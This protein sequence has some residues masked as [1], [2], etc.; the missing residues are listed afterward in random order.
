MPTHAAVARTCSFSEALLAK[1]HP[2]A[3]LNGSDKAAVRMQMSADGGLP[4]G[5]SGYQAI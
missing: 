2:K 5:A 4:T 3:L 1:P